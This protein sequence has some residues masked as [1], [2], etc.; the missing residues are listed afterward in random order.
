M[1]RFETDSEIVSYSSVVHVEAMILLQK[2]D[3]E[4]MPLRSYVPVSSGPA[5]QGNR[6]NG[7]GI[8]ARSEV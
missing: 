4:R 5:T 2:A 6:L 1:N 7:S 8:P 3:A